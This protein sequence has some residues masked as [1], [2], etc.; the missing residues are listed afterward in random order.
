MDIHPLSE[1]KAFA[2]VLRK[3]LLNLNKVAVSEGCQPELGEGRQAQNDNQ[4]GLCETAV[5]TDVIFGK[6]S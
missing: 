2:L 4:T 6:L 5:F 3:K 1:R